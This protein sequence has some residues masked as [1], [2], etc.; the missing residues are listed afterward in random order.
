MIKF[1]ELKVGFPSEVT[2]L[3]RLSICCKHYYP[4][5]FAQFRVIRVEF[6]G[7][8]NIVAGKMVP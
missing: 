6:V 2:A 3:R 7:S 4:T 5:I 1:N 8:I